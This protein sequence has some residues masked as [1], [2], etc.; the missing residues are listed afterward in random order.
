MSIVRLT[1]IFCIQK[2]EKYCQT[3]SLCFLITYNFYFTLIEKALLDLLDVDFFYHINVCTHD[4]K[5]LCKIK[6]YGILKTYSYQF[7]DKPQFL[8]IPKYEN[9]VY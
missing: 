4:K 7:L 5:N 9:N 3:I 8:E 1:L 6:C 2:K